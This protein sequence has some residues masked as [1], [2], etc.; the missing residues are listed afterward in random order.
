VF[1]GRPPGGASATLPGGRSCDG[2]PWIWNI[3]Q[4]LFPG[5]IQIVARFHV[6]ETPHRTAQSSFGAGDER[7]K[8]WAT[9]RCTELDEGGLGAIVQALRPYAESSTAAAKCGVYLYRNRQRM[10][11]PKFRE[12]GFCTST[13]GVEAGCKVSIGTRLKRAGMH[14]TLKGANAILALRCRHLKGSFQDFWE[15]RN[16]PIAA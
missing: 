10:R 3:A 4:G 16:D 11:Y 2:A 15:R 14:W 13:G 9:A 1:R 6:E 12:Q 5:A 8:L 7:S